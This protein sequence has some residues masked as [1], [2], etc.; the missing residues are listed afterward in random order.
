MIPGND[1]G[2]LYPE[3]TREKWVDSTINTIFILPKTRNPSLKGTYIPG[4]GE[5]P[6]Q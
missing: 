4:D 1:M 2:S 5:V 6:L 3:L